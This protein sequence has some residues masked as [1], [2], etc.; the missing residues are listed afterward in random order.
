[1]LGREAMKLLDYVECFP[2]G[3]KKGV[4]MVPACTKAGIEGFPTWIINDEVSLI[5]LASSFQSEDSFR[6]KF[7][8][9]VVL[10]SRILG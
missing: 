6:T 10:L 9:S 5:L 3:V 4:M 8:V 2:D 1:M 7:H